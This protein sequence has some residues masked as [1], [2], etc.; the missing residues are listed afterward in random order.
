MAE[1]LKN[2]QKRLDAIDKNID[3]WIEDSKSI[4]IKELMSSYEEL[5]R[6]IFQCIVRRKLL[7]RENKLF[8]IY[9]S[10]AVTAK[11]FLRLFRI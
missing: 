11:L 1:L 4:R 7:V 10:S 5:L 2:P 6:I 9:S 8:L 3:Q